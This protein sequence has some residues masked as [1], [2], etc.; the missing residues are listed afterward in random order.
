MGVAGAAAGR[1]QASVGAAGSPSPTSGG[2][3]GPWVTAA[4]AAAAVPCFFL[5]VTPL[6]PPSFTCHRH[7]MYLRRHP[8]AWWGYVY[9]FL[10]RHL[11]LDTTAL[12][13]AL[14]LGP[15]EVLHRIYL[16][17]A[18]L[19]V[20]PA[21]LIPHWLQ[22][23]SRHVARGTL[24]VWVHEKDGGCRCCCCQCWCWSLRS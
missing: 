16:S 17:S 23:I 24:R 6:I 4:A 1:W 5:P 20:V 18:T 11:R 7:I 10:C 3:A 12:G 14:N 13:A 19:I 21:E 22:Q 8:T 2:A 9:H 15:E